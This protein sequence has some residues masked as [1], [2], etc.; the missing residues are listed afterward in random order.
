MLGVTGLLQGRRDQSASEESGGL[1]RCHSG[2]WS[3][4]FDERTGFLAKELLP[5][6]GECRALLMLALMSHRSL[7]PV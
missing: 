3:N 1:S 2:A 4:S 6:D 7:A 5:W